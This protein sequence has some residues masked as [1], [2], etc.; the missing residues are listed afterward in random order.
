MD[1]TKKYKLT[2]LRD[3]E[4]CQA[5]KRPGQTFNIKAGQQL[6]DCTFDMETMSGFIC[7]FSPR[8]EDYVCFKTGNLKIEE[9][10]S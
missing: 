8:L 3:V 2:M 5:T 6:I 4:V 10:K 9:Q 1:K 7:F